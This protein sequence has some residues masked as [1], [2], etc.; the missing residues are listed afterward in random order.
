M[1]KEAEDPWQSAIEDFIRH[2]RT[3]RQLSPHTL[4]NYH[5]DLQSFADYC[6]Q[7]QTTPAGA[8]NSDVRQWVAALHRQGKS[9]ATLQR[10]LS[11]LRSFYRYR[12]RQSRGHN[13]V[14]GVSAPKGARSLPRAVDADQLQQFLDIPGD[15]WISVRDRAMLELFY[16]SGLRLSELVG[17]NLGDIDLA[18]GL[19]T[20]TGKGRKTR[21]V[22][23]GR[24]AIA[25][26]RQWLAQRDD[27]P[28]TNTAVF[29]S[30]RGQRIAPRTVQSRL[31]KYSLQQGLGQAI[32]PHMLRHSFASHLL[33][34]SSDL[35]AVQELLGHANI[36]TTQVYTHLDFQHL[37][38]VYDQAHPRAS[39]RNADG[40]PEGKK[41]PTES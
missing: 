9:S 35:R 10:G 20:V 8:H 24:H 2:L 39:R 33:E 13:P 32:H 15:D 41:E 23:V 1:V 14:T 3:E 30:K 22:P 36:S 16:S 18:E 34:S 27:V 31:K 21:T 40:E 28:S 38:K 17:L 6:Q 19:V 12:A 37:A 29:T 4:S 5:R 25:A 7:R 11:A 26:L